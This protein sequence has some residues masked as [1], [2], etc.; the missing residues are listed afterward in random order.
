MDICQIIQELF[1]LDLKAAKV[2]VTQEYSS[3]ENQPPWPQSDTD[4][5]RSSSVI[6]ST[7]KPVNH[8]KELI[9]FTT[10]EYPYNLPIQIIVMLESSF[11]NSIM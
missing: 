1:S 7:I 8:S 3:E 10:N 11:P 2:Y 6:E 4:S 9:N 5:A